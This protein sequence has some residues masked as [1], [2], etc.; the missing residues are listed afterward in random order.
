M[1]VRLPPERGLL[2]LMLVAAALGAA[3]TLGLLGLIVALFFVEDG[4]SF[5]LMIIGLLAVGATSGRRLRMRSRKARHPLPRDTERVRRALERLAAMADRPVPAVEIVRARPPLSWTTVTLRG[6]PTVHVTTAL[7]DRVGERELRAVLAHELAHVLHRDALLMTVLAGPSTWAAQ[8]ARHLVDEDPLRGTF[9]VICFVLP[10]APVLLVSALLAR[11]VSRHR[12][13][14]AD[15][16][17]V[18][19]TGSAAAVAAALVAVDDELRRMPKRDLRR[20][21]TLDCFNF[22]P[23]RPAPR[24]LR[25]WATHPP[26]A[27]RLERLDRF[28]RAL[29]GR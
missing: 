17:A 29:Q 5:A 27:R 21:G 22:V 14:A 3:L 26:V 10:L 24:W 4:W 18:V 2:A 7:L 16:A 12:E 20:A 9:A 28:E 13:L 8:A 11:L 15:R 23:A 19:L 6:R 25:F 1:V